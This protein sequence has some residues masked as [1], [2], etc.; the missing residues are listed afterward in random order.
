[1]A[2][3]NMIAAQRI[4]QHFEASQQT[5]A[6]SLS[7]LAPVITDA[8]DR[9]CDALAKGHKILVCGN[10]GSAADALHFSSELLNKYHRQR[11]PLG[12][13][14]LNADTSTL[15]SIANDEDYQFVFS[16]QIEALAKPGDILV[17]FSTSGQ[18]PNVLRAVEAA[19]NGGIRT[20]AMSGK[21]GGELA[22]TLLENDIE[23]RV[24]SDVTARI[25]EV[26][27]LIIHC[28]CDVIDHALFG[29]SH[30]NN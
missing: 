5:L 1:M 10:G 12:S 16:K 27:G 28:F 4:Q 8:C 9:L 20:I 13:I 2:K 14:C 22:S 11:R 30:D 23:I 3:L 15:T 24:P 26:H 21:S 25:Q 29:E 17:A 7:Q 6:D 18:S 19:Q